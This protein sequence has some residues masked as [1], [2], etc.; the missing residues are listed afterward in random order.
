MT[1]KISWKILWVLLSVALPA[2]GQRGEG[3][4]YPALRLDGQIQVQVDDGDLQSG[5]PE[6]SRPVRNGIGIFPTDTRLSP[7]RIRL[8]P[9]LD[10]SPRWTILNQVDLDPDG[11]QQED[12]ELTV[13]DLYLRYEIEKGHELRLGQTKVPFGY[14]NLRSSERIFTI[15][16]SD[17]TRQLF[18]RDVGLVAYGQTDRWE[19]GAG[20]FQGQGLNNQERNGSQDFVGKVVYRVLP[21]LKLGFSGQ[22][23]TYR[24]RSS[25]SDLKVR[26]VGMELRYQDGPLQFE[27]EYIV[28]EGFNLFS[29]TD[30]NSRGYYLYG[31][32]KIRSDLEFVA[33]YD[34][35][36]PSLG[37]VNEIRADNGVNERDR[38]T[39]GLNYY[40]GRSPVHRVMLNYEF[41]RELEGPSVASRGLR[42]RYQYAW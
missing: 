34:R 29:E 32:Y 24:P 5:R 35:Y 1:S 12:L 10:L 27:G 22:T 36:D 31:L 16:R 30:S 8:K 21:A 6:G 2:L 39:L 42:F 14:E 3:E 17:V 37:R 41:R 23:G 11:F 19:Y 7:R 38:W 15:E 13:L 40:L 4:F 33:G 20:V 28:G 9:R 26:R 25:G 18:Q